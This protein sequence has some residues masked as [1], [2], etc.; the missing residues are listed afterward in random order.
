[1]G[2]AHRLAGIAQ[3]IF[4]DHLVTALA[5]SNADGRLIVLVSKFIINGR[6]VEV[7]LACEFRLEVLD[8]E[9]DHDETAQPQVIEEKV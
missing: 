1:M 9:L 6:E 3:G 7:H 5:Q 2:D 8:L 4:D